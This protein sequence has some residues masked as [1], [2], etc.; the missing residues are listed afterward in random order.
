MLFDSTCTAY[1]E[2]ETLSGLGVICC[3][4]WDSEKIFLKPYHGG[5]QTYSTQQNKVNMVSCSTS[6]YPFT[7]TESLPL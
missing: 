7:I 3:T 2:N 6:L 1:G 4:S 5:I